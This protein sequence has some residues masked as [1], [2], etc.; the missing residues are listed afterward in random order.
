V[1]STHRDKASVAATLLERVANGSLEPSAALD[2][3]PSGTE[4]DD[5]LN[6]GWHDLS[7]FAADSDI[8]MK[9]SRYRSHQIALLLK[10]AKD[11][12]DKHQIS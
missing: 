8:R 10:R 7:H 2:E 11:I 4:S 12:K 5:V 9:D 1:S 6:V 3:W